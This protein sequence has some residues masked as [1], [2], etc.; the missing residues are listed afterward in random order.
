MPT[1]FQCCLNTVVSKPKLTH[2]T[3]GGLGASGVGFWLRWVALGK[4][5]AQLSAHALLIVKSDDLL[6]HGCPIAKW[7]AS[8][9]PNLLSYW[10]HNK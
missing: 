2:F 10:N 8:P 9:V 4:V 1:L 7:F 5:P 6:C 3:D